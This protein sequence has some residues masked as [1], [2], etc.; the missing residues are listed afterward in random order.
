MSQALGCIKREDEGAKRIMFLSG[1]PQQI[2]IKVGK[3]RTRVM[4]L[5]SKVPNAEKV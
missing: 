1:Q 5:T 3:S 4:E 2:Q